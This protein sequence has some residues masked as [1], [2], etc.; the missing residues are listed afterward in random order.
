MDKQEIANLIDI[1]HSII[2]KMY[3][4]NPDSDFSWSQAHEYAMSKANA[5][6]VELSKSIY[7]MQGC[8]DLET[9]LSWIHHVI[10]Q[11]DAGTFPDLCDM[12]SATRY[13]DRVVKEI[14]KIYRRPEKPPQRPTNL[15][16]GII[17]GC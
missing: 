14:R 17:T 11:Y 8:T 12:H 16:D 4:R 10:Y 9:A 15:D 6:L 1:V 7:V 3:M 5:I 13:A 2:Y